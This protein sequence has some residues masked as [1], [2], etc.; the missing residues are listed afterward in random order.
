VR[1]APNDRRLTDEGGRFE[2]AV[3]RTR[4]VMID[5]RRVGFRPL[6]MK[7][8]IVPDTPIVLVMRSLAATLEAVR[9]E[10]DR[11][12]RSLELGGF[13]RRMAD[14][15]K[16][17]GSG[18]Y[19]TPEDIERRRV[20]RVTQLLE[21]VSGVRVL[22]LDQWGRRWGVFGNSRCPMTIYLNRIRLNPLRTQTW[23]EFDSLV[24][25]TNVAGIEVYARSNAPP[26]FQLMAGSCGI[27]LIWTK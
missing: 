21:G 20:N 2:V 19:L 10:T 11:I 13:Y 16:G 14:R 17:V 7:L 9:I 23:V 25:P 18:I 4:D 3:H 12:V 5:V 1:I 22:P 24:F 8:A 6:E 27:V 15:A 26:E